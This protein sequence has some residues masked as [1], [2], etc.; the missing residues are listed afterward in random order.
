MNDTALVQKVWNYAH[1]LR[2]QGVPY[3]AYIS[4]ISYLLLLKMDEERAGLAALG[5][6][7]SRIGDPRGLPLAARVESERFRRSAYAGLA[8]RDK[9][10]LDIFWLKDVA[11]DD[12]DLL[13]AAA[14]NRRRDRRKP[15]NGPRPFSQTRA[16][17][18]AGQS[19][20]LPRR[21]SSAGRNSLEPPRRRGRR[22]AALRRRCRRARRGVIRRRR[23]ADP[24]EE[25]EPQVGEAPGHP[26][27]E[28]RLGDGVAGGG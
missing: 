25:R 9:V 23:G 27:Q 19:D 26:A 16:E 13:A 10:N 21:V 8:L 1:V 11:L 20:Q 24:F 6:R 5:A 22:N 4:Q 2:D 28:H 15:G 14:R 7:T 17:P 12:P 3:Q 18:A